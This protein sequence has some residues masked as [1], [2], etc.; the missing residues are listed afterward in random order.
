MPSPRSLLSSDS[1]VRRE[2]VIR[3]LQDGAVTIDPTPDVLAEANHLQSLGVIQVNIAHFVR[4]SDPRD[5][6]FAEGDHLCPGRIYVPEHL[7]DESP[8]DFCCPACDRPIFPVTDEK[9]RH[10]ELVC[11]IVPVGVIGW[12][13]SLLEIAMLRTSPVC[14]GVLRLDV[15]V[16]GVYLCVV[17]ICR[18]QNFLS[19][20]WAATQ[21]TCYVLVN[22][23]S[24]RWR[25]VGEP[26]LLA[27]I[28]CGH[29]DLVA[30]VRQTAAAS[31]PV[32]LQYGIVPLYGE[33]R[34]LVSSV[35]QIGQRHFAVAMDHDSVW[36]E[37][38]QVIGR[39]AG[40]RLEVF[41]LLWNAYLEDLRCGIPPAEFH[42][43]PVRVI[44]PLLESRLTSRY[45]DEM[46]VRRMINHVQA[47]VERIV[48]RKLG[49]P[50]GRNSIVQTC[51]WRGQ[52]SGD[53]GYR[54]NPS[55]VI[56]AA[57][58]GTGRGLS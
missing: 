19:P 3:L 56:V 38:L 12:L 52:D 2:R 16:L 1:A 6:D 42:A 26:V 40:P 14:E 7:N 5:A 32:Q 18:Q 22:A 44:Q 24:A 49:L 11:R 15:G 28:I 50:I 48:R 29:A 36:V 13:T 41:R 54:L 34:P 43:Q 31:E 58:P 51:R 8:E 27:D 35:P 33:D 45:P 25:A 4:C 9:Q 30:K 39:H 37:G 10:Q 55:C 46:T 21:P 17:D 20:A 47:D 53:Y 57:P 23:K